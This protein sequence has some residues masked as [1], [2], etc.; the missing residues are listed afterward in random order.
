MRNDKL[1]EVTRLHCHYDDRGKFMELWKGK[2]FVQVNVGRSEQYV[3][4]GLHYQWPRP[5]GK[6]VTVLHGQAIDVA[7]DLRQNSPTFGH[8]QS[9]YLDGTVPTS[10]WVPPG[11]AHGILALSQSMSFT[12]AL[13]D[14][15][16]PEYAKSLAWNDPKLGIAWGINRP[17]LSEKDRTAPLLAEIPL[18]NL[19]K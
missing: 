10:V 11:F 18:E 1:V 9:T 8:W 7:V 19:P 15:Y 13:D 5:S 6:L 17:V 16:V 4:R 3:L 14:E 2:Q 12:Y